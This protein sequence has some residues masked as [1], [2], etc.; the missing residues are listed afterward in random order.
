MFPWIKISR[1]C[2][3]LHCNII[4][5]G[6]ILYKAIYKQALRCYGFCPRDSWS[7]KYL[8]LRTLTVIAIG[9]QADAEKSCIEK[10]GTGAWCQPGGCCVITILASFSSQRS[11]CA[12]K[13][14]M[15]DTICANKKNNKMSEC[16][17]AGLG[18][19]NV[20]SDRGSAT[21]CVLLNR[22]FVLGLLWIF[23]NACWSSLGSKIC[24][25]ESIFVRVTLHGT[26]FLV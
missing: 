16:L 13:I 11:T 21:S 22:I 2:C 7:S 8:S 17:L 24:K 19:G 14:L 23:A 20:T 15:N 3:W 6:V 10:A 26:P 1:G 5:P 9:Q 4:W 25:I 18:F 12:H